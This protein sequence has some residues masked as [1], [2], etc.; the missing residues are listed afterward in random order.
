MVG[1]ARSC[2]ADQRAAYTSRAL[3]IYGDIVLNWSPAVIADM[4]HLIG[5][6]HDTAGTSLVKGHDT[7]GTMHNRHASKTKNWS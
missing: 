7:A 4:G 5:K 6:G 3:Q 1:A 2:T